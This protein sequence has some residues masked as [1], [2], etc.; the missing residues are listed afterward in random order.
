MGKEVNCSL[1]ARRSLRE[2]LALLTIAAS[3]ELEADFWSFCHFSDV[4]WGLQWVKS[5][6]KEDWFVR[7]TC[8][9][10]TV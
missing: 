2:P 8:I 3:M 4:A 7:E 10:G 6:V 5:M 9:K 1:W